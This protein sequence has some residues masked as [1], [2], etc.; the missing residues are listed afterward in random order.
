M[1]LPDLS[2][3]PR[4]SRASLTDL[5]LIGFSGALL[6]LAA[7]S[8]WQA[9][10]DRDQAEARLSF[11]RSESARLRAD[12]RRARS[13][14][15]GVSE[16][17]VTPL[18]LSV[19]APPALVAR[20]VAKN[21]PSRARLRSLALRY[22]DSLWIDMEVTAADAEVYDRLVESLLAAPRFQDLLPGAEA[23]EGEIRSSLSA[24]FVPEAP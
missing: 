16:N 1:G 6:A 24:R 19:E 4:H 11:V 9:V 13:Q 15:L 18:L 5:L 20:E 7:H 12:S 2:T 3:R 21:L 10:R 14:G 23:R 17:V 22:T 8:A